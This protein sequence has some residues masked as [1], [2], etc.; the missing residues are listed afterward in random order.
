MYIK[1][2]STVI[3]GTQ[4]AYNYEV[5]SESDNFVNIPSNFKN[6]GQLYH[7][8]E[9]PCDIIYHLLDEELDYDGVINA[10]ELETARQEHLGWYFSINQTK[11]INSKKFIENIAKQSKL[12]PKFRSD[13]SFGFNTIKD[14]YTEEDVDFTVYENEIIDYI[15]KP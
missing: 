2:L 6:I 5:I 8:I 4:T 13:D 15:K 3:T 14:V 12:F 7:F 9:M 10:E 11:N 1:M